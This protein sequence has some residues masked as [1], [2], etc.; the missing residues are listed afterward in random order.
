MCKEQPG[1]QLVL[2]LFRHP[3][4]HMVPRPLTAGMSAGMALRKY[5]FCPQ[6][7]SELSLSMSVLQ[8]PECLRRQ[9]WL[10]FQP[11]PAQQHLAQTLVAQFL[12]TDL[13]LLMRLC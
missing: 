9:H 4:P 10:R 13:L 11:N 8:P 5:P 6:L 3:K 12:L 1:Y 7:R 2:R